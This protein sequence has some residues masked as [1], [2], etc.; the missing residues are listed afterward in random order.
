[1]INNLKKYKTLLLFLGA[2][3]AIFLGGKDVNYWGLKEPTGEQILKKVEAR[4]IDHEKIMLTPKQEAEI[5]E[6]INKN[7][8]EYSDL[9]QSLI[10]TKTGK[11]ILDDIET[12]NL[13]P[14]TVLLNARQIKEITKLIT[15]NP[16]SYSE[17]QQYLVRE[18]TAEEILDLVGFGIK[19]PNLITLTPKQ[20]QEIKELIMANP[21]KYNIAQKALIP[22]LNK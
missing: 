20:H 18:K 6:L 14:R 7:P 17:K 11:E 15:T 8:A 12:K 21:T 19:S 13:D 10:S 4:K 2:V 16:T 5:K 1:M 3:V 22:E 9:Q